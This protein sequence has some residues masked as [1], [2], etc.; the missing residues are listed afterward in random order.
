[1][2]YFKNRQEAGEKLAKVL[3]QY[4]EVRQDGRNTVVVSLLRGGVVLGSILAKVLHLP[5]YP[6]VVAKIAAPFPYSPE[7]AIGATCEGFIYQDQAVL[8]TLNLSSEQIMRQIQQ[9]KHKQQ[10]YK[11]KFSLDNINY[12]EI[13]QGKNIF[14]VDDGV[15]TGS[16]VEAAARFIKS[17][18]PKKLIL[19]VP[20]APAE[21]ETA[22]FDKVLVLKREVNFAAVAQFYQ[23]ILPSL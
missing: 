12:R 20:V 18:Q 13:L 8:Q 23:D 21:F 11:K 14:L 6:L 17:L 9:A 15:A 19:A 10:T 3:S 22:S 7:L 5:H 4:P 16:T 2:K 1:M